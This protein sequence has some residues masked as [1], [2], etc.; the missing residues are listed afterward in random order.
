VGVSYY[1]RPLTTEEKRDLVS[2][3]F[4]C[5]EK[6][7]GRLAKGSEILEALQEMHGFTVQRSSDS[8]EMAIRSKDEAIGSWADLRVSKRL[9]LDLE[10]EFD[11]ERGW[12]DVI[13]CFLWNLAKRTGPWVVMDD[14]GIPLV[15]TSEKTV[16]TL[17]EEWENGEL[18]D[19]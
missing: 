7:S 2:D 19:E 13:V 9:E 10:T 12:P 15:V 3:G 1:V 14:S 16:A 17:L 11:F 18:P 5:T 8:R 4:E 6:A